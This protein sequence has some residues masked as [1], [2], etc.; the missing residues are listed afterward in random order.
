LPINS[1]DAYWLKK[2]LKQQG[3]S[4]VKQAKFADTL[5]DYAD[6]DNRRRPAGGE[7]L[8]YQAGAKP[9]DFLL[10]SC[11]ELWLVTSWSPLLA[12]Q[13]RL[14]GHCSLRRS[15]R[16]NLNSVPLELWQVLWPNT[17]K[18]I[19]A[20]RQQGKW[21]ASVQNIL[22]LEP[23][24]LTVPETYYSYLGGTEFTLQLSQDGAALKIRIQ[25][26]RGDNSPY[27]LKYE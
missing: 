23:R 8:S 10:Q 4:R 25:T 13:N 6:P 16:L 22:A 1:A 24:L 26:G 2:W 17:L 11:N 27:V 18:K 3:Y 15:A 7:K 21:F 20:Q 14:I 12:A 19:K 5:A 9:R